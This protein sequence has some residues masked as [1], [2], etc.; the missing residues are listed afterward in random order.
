MYCVLNVY[1]SFQ[2]FLKASGKIKKHR[3]SQKK[4]RMVPNSTMSESQHQN[5]RDSDVINDKP[6][7]V[8]EQLVDEF[9]QVNIRYHGSI[10]CVVGY[11]VM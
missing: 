11:D 7:G 4:T 9:F 1:N 10:Q 3:P 6:S 8:Q 2:A 5:L